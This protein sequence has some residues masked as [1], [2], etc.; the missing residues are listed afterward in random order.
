MV[1]V[2]SMHIRV[3]TL[4]S[5]G[6]RLGG[7]LV[8]LTAFRIVSCDLLY[9]SIPTGEAGNHELRGASSPTTWFED[10]S[11]LKQAETT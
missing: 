2:G 1:P 10:F 11:E 4:L 5:S 8:Y 6:K 7:I 3:H 9:K